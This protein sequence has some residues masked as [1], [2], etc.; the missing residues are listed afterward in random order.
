MK[1]YNDFCNLHTFSPVPSTMTSY[2]SSMLAL[3]SCTKVRKADCTPTSQSLRRRE[4][5]ELIYTG[6]G[7]KHVENLFWQGIP[8]VVE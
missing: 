6:C 3:T 7:S 8:V 2:S 4:N 5:G 1:Y